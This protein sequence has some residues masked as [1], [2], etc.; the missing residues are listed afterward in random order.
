M[1]QLAQPIARRPQSVCSRLETPT[2]SIR[3]RT[4]LPCT[5]GLPPVSIQLEYIDEVDLSRCESQGVDDHEFEP[6]PEREIGRDMIAAQH[7]PSPIQESCD[8]ANALEIFAVAGSQI[9]KLPCD[10]FVPIQPD[11]SRDTRVPAAGF[12]FQSLTHLQSNEVVVRVNHILA[13]VA[14]DEDVLGRP[15]EVFVDFDVADTNQVIAIE[16]VRRFAPPAA[17]GV[18]HHLVAAQSLLEPVVEL[19]VVQV[20]VVNDPLEARSVELAVAAVQVERY[21]QTIRA[22]RRNLPV[23]DPIAGRPSGEFDRVI[24]IIVVAKQESTQS[25][26]H[27]R[28]AA[29]MIRRNVQRSIRIECQAYGRETVGNGN[30]RIVG[31][32]ERGGFL[33][34]SVQND[35]FGLGVPQPATQ[36]R[37]GAVDGRRLGVPR[38]RAPGPS[39]I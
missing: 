32:R 8:S 18:H 26:P 17:V 34:G 15:V 10:G 25:G 1:A 3:S 21:E 19:K 5:T 38:D 16:S 24:A 29:R 36:P 27:A 13:V 14:V 23:A 33:P 9:K 11:L 20:A 35:S 30:V 37:P 6:G 22:R 2:N 28:V 39:P 31:G 4:C 12:V 7:L